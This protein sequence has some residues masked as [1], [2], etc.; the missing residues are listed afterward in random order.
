MMSPILATSEF[1]RDVFTGPARD[2]NGPTTT[3]ISRSRGLQPTNGTYRTIRQTARGQVPNSCVLC[4][5]LHV[6]SCRVVLSSLPVDPNTTYLRGRE[7]I[8]RVVSS[9][10]V[11]HLHTLQQT[12]LIVIGAIIESLMFIGGNETG[13][14]R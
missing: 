10:R 11:S 12:C 8:T 9:G 3:Y 4:C 13:F 5:R 2:H 7:D 14:I 1:P 6:M